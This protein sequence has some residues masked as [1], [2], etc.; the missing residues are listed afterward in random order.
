LA[1]SPDE[2]AALLD[3]FDTEA[4]QATLAKDVRAYAGELLAGLRSDQAIIPEVHADAAR[5]VALVLTH[6]IRNPE[7]CGA[8][9]NLGFGLRRLAI[10]DSEAVKALR[11]ERALACFDRAL[12][13]SREHR[14]VA[15]RAWAGKALAFR[16]LER[17]DN[18]VRSA[19]EALNLDPS[20]PNL[21]LLCSYC[22][23][24]AGKDDEASESVHGAF[25]AYVA[26]GRPEGLRHIFE[27]DVL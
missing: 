5:I 19:R 4:D 14:P 18:A 21:W 20:D 11:L 27:N 8:W 15:I 6:H 9:L 23:T 7:H 1:D 26:A 10:S 13:L 12:A 3:W 22:L 25:D 17:F 16:Q 24:V 2:P